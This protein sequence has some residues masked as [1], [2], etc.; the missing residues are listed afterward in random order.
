M[1]NSK[2]LAKN[3][4]IG[5]EKQSKGSGSVVIASKNKILLTLGIAA[6]IILCAGVFY[7][8]LRPR[9]VLKVT[10]TN[11]DG[12]EKTNTVYMKEAVYDIY[13]LETQF[14]SYASLYQQMYGTT[15]W[16]MENADEDGRNGASAAK[17]QVMDGLKQKEILYMEA[18][19]LGHALTDEEK[20]A[21]DESATKAM[22]SMTD[23]QK[24]L[25]GLDEEKYLRK[26]RWFKN[27]DK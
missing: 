21:A 16:E 14:N 1:N 23:G 5:S 7:M 18:Q 6:I 9:A 15:Y 10:Q 20:K 27:I 25:P 19:K 17:K 8:Q 24:K 26:M 4:G 11:E 22:E 3:G 2:K 12:G 13:T